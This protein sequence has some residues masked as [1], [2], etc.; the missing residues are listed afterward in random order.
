MTTH[1]DLLISEFMIRSLCKVTFHGTPFFRPQ[2]IV[3]VGFQF[4]HLDVRAHVLNQDTVSLPSKKSLP[5]FKTVLGS[6]P[7]IQETQE[8][9]LTASASLTS[10]NRTQHVS[11][12]QEEACGEGGARG[13]HGTLREAAD[14]EGE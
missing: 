11:G 7:A 2:E 4:R 8:Q 1:H 5:I 6:E 13:A 10:Q 14:R 3:K 12:H 9:E